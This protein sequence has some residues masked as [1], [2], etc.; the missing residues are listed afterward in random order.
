[1]ESGLHGEETWNALWSASGK[2]Q[3]QKAGCVSGWREVDVGVGIT[4]SGQS[5]T[6]KSRAKCLR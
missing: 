5:G 4:N 1:M 6:T 3:R 2:C